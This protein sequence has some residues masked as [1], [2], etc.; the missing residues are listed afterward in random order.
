MGPVAKK[1]DYRVWLIYTWKKVIFDKQW[2]QCI[3]FLSIYQ[4]F[5]GWEWQ[6]EEKKWGIGEQSNF[7]RKGACHLK[8][9]DGK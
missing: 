7:A 6:T 1:P 4:F 5:L 9:T 3:Y 2:I 8:K